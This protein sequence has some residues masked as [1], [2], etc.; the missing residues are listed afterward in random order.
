MTI[1]VLVSLDVP[2]SLDVANNSVLSL[3]VANKSIVK[4]RRTQQIF[5]KFRRSESGL[6]PLSGSAAV[7]R[8][9]RSREELTVCERDSAGC[10]DRGVRNTECGVLGAR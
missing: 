4:C 3:D 9:L 5:V 8:S 1:F 10:T 6:G 2:L 7:P